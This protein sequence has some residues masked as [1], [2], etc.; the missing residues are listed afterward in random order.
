MA[1]ISEN[2]LTRDRIITNGVFS[3]NLVTEKILPLADYFGNKSGYDADKMKIDVKT[4]KGKVLN[5]PILTESPV[6]FELEVAKVINLDDGMIFFCKIRNVLA[7]ESLTDGNISI[8]ERMKS[9][10]P[11]CT[12][13]Q[14]YFGWNGEKAGSW[15]DFKD[16]FSGVK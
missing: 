12:T 16:V 15:G 7:D 8:E 6:A 3:A 4:E 10:A 11:I 5:V 14:T 13:C 2:K 1:C 9:I